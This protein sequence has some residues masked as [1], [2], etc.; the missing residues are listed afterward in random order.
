MCNRP[1]LLIFLFLM[2]FAT[3]QATNRAYPAG[4]LRFQHLNSDMGLS[5]NNVNAIIQ[6][7]KGFMWFGTENG[8]NRFDGF[9]IRSYFQD[10]NDSASL[11]GNGIF[12]F[13]IDKNKRLWVGTNSG[14][15]YYDEKRQQ[16]KR[17]DRVTFDGTY[18]LLYYCQSLDETSDGWV[19]ACSPDMLVAYNIN[20]FERQI[21][22]TFDLL[23]NRLPNEQLFGMQVDKNDDIWI[24]S[25]HRVFSLTR[26]KPSELKIFSHQMGHVR[27]LKETNSDTY[28]VC[29]ESG[30]FTLNIKTGVSKRFIPQNAPDPSVFYDGFWNIEI[31]QD[32][33][34]WLA[35][36]GSGVFMYNPAD[37]SIQHYKFEANNPESLSN[38]NVRSIY[39]D[40]AGIVWIG[41]QHAGINYAHIKPKKNFRV[42]SSNA[43]QGRNLSMNVVT[44]IEEDDNHLW[45]G[46]D[47]AGINMIDKSTFQVKHIAIGPGSKVKN[48][49][50]VILTIKNDQKGNLWMGGHNSLALQYSIGEKKWKTHK[51]PCSVEGCSGSHH[52]W[53]ITIDSSGQIWFA[54]NHHGIFVRDTSGAFRHLSIYYSSGGENFALNASECQPNTLWVGTYAGIVL[55]DTRTYKVIRSFQ[56]VDNNP[57][58]LSHNWVYYIH[59]DS[60]GNIWVGTSQGLNRYHPSDSSFTHFGFKDG[61]SGDIINAIEEDAKGRLWL[62]TNKGIVRFDH[63]NNSFVNYSKNDGLP[64]DEYFMGSSYRDRNGMI[65]FGSING[66]VYFDPD[67]IRP[68]TSPPPVVVTDIQV[69]FADIDPSVY[70]SIKKDKE[71]LVFKHKQSTISFKYV[72]LNYIGNYENQYHYQLEGLDP[73]WI[74][75][76]TRKEAVFTNLSPGSYTFRVKYRNKDG[77]W[78]ENEASVSFVILHPWWD[79]VLFKIFLLIVLFGVS[80]LVLKLR[81]QVIERK[82]ADLEEQIR[83]KT[84]ELKSKNTDL[85][86]KSELMNLINQE[87]S[88]HKNRLENQAKELK[89]FN[90]QLH[91]LNPTKD[92]LITILAHDLKSPFQTILGMSSLLVS[93][94][95]DFD[96][97]RK[98][99]MMNRLHSSIEKTY[100]LLENL[101]LWSRTQRQQIKPEPKNILLIPITENTISLVSDQADSKN[102]SIVLNGPKDIEAFADDEMVNT[103]IRNL[104][105]NAIKFS[106]EGSS[107]E[108][109]FTEENSFIL[110]RITDFGVGM[111]YEA[112]AKLFKLDSTQSSEGTKGEKGT[113]LGLL[114]CSDLIRLIDGKIWVESKPGKGTSFFFTIP[115]AKRTKAQ[116]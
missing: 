81:F 31:D 11:S 9:Y 111:S 87:L 37:G 116:T 94:E 54:T 56:K 98:T 97:A 75:A 27:R 15:S 57:R 1:V 72:G 13:H 41:T 33:K 32:Q 95:F 5:S 48:T 58:S 105:T 53:G 93:Q 85:E 47:G 43:E 24:I 55:I 4:P 20:T 61:F 3:A 68:D 92:K 59:R 64:S 8:I 36:L 82:K 90:A 100:S 106:R 34:V 46:T 39:T 88:I 51:L 102:I 113:G 17:V 42:L 67:E 38:N 91:N 78:G 7:H 29:S 35:S 70:A 69:H 14:L 107:V 83:I 19:I 79:T 73:Q 50:N 114:L 108:I 62:S 18:D 115:K 112:Q 6:D 23:G 110:C 12:S 80:L 2:V 60:E 40:K 89:S 16:F 77:Y 96:E 44:S 21:L 10:P 25:Q 109:S 28:W 52:I 101:L 22:F 103:I 49:S 66:L 84:A 45:V 104:L 86:N 26:A 74:N 30:L 76:G 65:Y 63:R 71:I 99:D